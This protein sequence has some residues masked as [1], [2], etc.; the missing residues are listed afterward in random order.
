MK[1]NKSKTGIEYLKAIYDKDYRCPLVFEAAEM[2]QM[3]IM[4]DFSRWL[5]KESWQMCSVG[6][7]NNEKLN[8][9]CVNLGQLYQEF[10]K[11][12]NK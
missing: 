9:D 5:A 1:K 7:W 6:F 8:E 2:L 4:K 11:S 10:L 12:R 3:E